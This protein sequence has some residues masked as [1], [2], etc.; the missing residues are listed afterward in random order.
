MIF[1]VLI[2]CGINN[3]SDNYN[4]CSN[5]S[6]DSDNKHNFVYR[7]LG[8]WLSIA[9]VATFTSGNARKQQF[10]ELSV[11]RKHNSHIARPNLM[12]QIYAVSKQFYAV[13]A[14]EAS[15][16]MQQWLYAVIG[17]LTA[18]VETSILTLAATAIAVQFTH[19]NFIYS[20]GHINECRDTLVRLVN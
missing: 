8:S 13:A 20:H 12:P 1:G 18:I 5:N 4:N 9:T 7:R 11:R 15:K 14:I 19:A 16:R 3:N 10:L 2:K 6:I 17:M